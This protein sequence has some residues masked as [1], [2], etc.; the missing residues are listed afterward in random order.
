MWAKEIKNSPICSVAKPGPKITVELQASR[1]TNK[2]AAANAKRKA[3]ELPV[4]IGVVPVVSKEVLKERRRRKQ[5][6]KE[7][8]ELKRL[9]QQ[10]NI[11]GF[12][13]YSIGIVP[14][15]PWYPP[16]IPQYHQPQA[17]FPS[18]YMPSSSPSYGY[19]EDE[20]PAYRAPRTPSKGSYIKVA[21]RT[22]SSPMSG[23]VAIPIQ[24][25]ILQRVC[26]ENLPHNKLG[27]LEKIFATF[28]GA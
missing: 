11:S 8:A 10:P 18:Q 12:Q 13:S 27:A 6:E 22:R 21:D 7:V 2:A 16:P 14:Q 5:L 1:K 3:K 9:A 20:L 26:R 23:S 15:Q 25:E 28:Q 19:K 4:S 17:G 24:L